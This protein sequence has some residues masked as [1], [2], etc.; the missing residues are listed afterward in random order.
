MNYLKQRDTYEE[1]K[2]I[3]N[4]RNYNLVV[5]PKEIDELTR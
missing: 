3:L 2:Q 5:T 1:I 4:P